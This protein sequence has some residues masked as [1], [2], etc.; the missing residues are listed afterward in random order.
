MGK[1]NLFIVLVLAF[2]A[3]AQILPM[4]VVFGSDESVTLDI[5]GSGPAISSVSL[6]TN[7]DEATTSVDPEAT[8]KF[9]FSVS[10][11]NTLDDLANIVVKIYFEASTTDAIRSCYTFTWTEGAGSTSFISSPSDYVVVSSITP[12]AEQELLGSF[13]FELHFKLDGV[14][15]PSGSTSTWHID[16]TAT[17]DSSATDSDTST[18]FDVAKYQSIG[19]STATIPFGSTS[20]GTALAKQLVTVTLTANTQV[21][22]DVQGA[23][24]IS[25]S[26]SIPANQFNAWDDSAGSPSAHVLSTSA[27]TVYSG[28]EANSD[29]LNSGVTGYTDNGNADV[30]FDGTVPS[31]QAQGSYTGLW[32]ISLDQIDVTPN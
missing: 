10:D 2:A 22:I 25:G 6:T 16:V 24:L 11:S 19:V 4:A 20:P 31:P 32:T 26:N 7:S 17:D 23:A 1:K 27:T 30:G 12:T 29:T 14:A 3:F 21:N 8:Y 28:Y 5:N 9:K 15:V 18:V 13:N